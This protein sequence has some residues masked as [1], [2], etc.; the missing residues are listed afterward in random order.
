MTAKHSP[1]NIERFAEFIA[2]DYNLNVT[3]DY[4]LELLNA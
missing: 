1:Q 3:K 4:A 2:R